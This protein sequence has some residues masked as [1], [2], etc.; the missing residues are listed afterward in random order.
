MPSAASVRLVEVWHTRSTEPLRRNPFWSVEHNGNLPSGVPLDNKTQL[1][2]LPSELLVLIFEELGGRELRRSALNLTVCRKW[3]QAAH[4][5]YLSG[6]ETSNIHIYGCDIGDLSRKWSYQNKRVLMHRNTRELR[7]QLLGHWWDYNSKALTEDDAEATREGNE[8]PAEFAAPQGQKE[9]REWQ[10]K[11]L[12][13]AMN[14]LF[15]D[16]SRFGQLQRVSLECLLEF[17]NHN[18][19]QWEYL[20]SS[21][22]ATFLRNLP[23]AHDLRSLTLDLCSGLNY[24]EINDAH[25]CEEVAQVL[26]R[27]EDVRIRLRL[28][29]P[30]I[31]ELQETLQAGDVRLKRLVIK[32]HLPA[33]RWTNYCSK[34]CTA[35]DNSNNHL[36]GM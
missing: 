36:F 26:P 4:S 13:P 19:P 6:L 5:V 32:L 35:V 27:I 30:S 15:G 20:T 22:I 8:P 25:I 29:C 11:I 10:K 18:G 2:D 34:Y 14:E 1:L 3:F 9:V 21:T 17:D 16:L 12:L 7:I 24:D 23:I 33:F 28:I 31:F